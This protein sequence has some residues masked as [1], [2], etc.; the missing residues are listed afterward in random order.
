MKKSVSRWVYR[1]VMDLE[2]GQSE[3]F[4]GGTGL[5]SVFGLEDGGY[6]AGFEA[7]PAY[8]QEGAGQDPNHMS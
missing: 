2:K 7:A 8:F 1:L 5:F 4:G 3:G 6:L